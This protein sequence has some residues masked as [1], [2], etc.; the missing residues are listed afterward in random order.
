L[1]NIGAGDTYSRY[2]S[3]AGDAESASNLSNQCRIK[4]KQ[5]WVIYRL[6]SRAVYLGQVTAPDTD[7]A[8]TAIKI[9]IKTLPDRDPE[10][11]KRLVTRKA[12]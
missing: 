12:D 7:T 9:A 5:T 6:S 8:I 3:A 2:P 1:E 10:H 4:E 11:Q